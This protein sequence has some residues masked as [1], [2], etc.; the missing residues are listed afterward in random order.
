MRPGVGAAVII[1]PATVAL[2]VGVLSGCGASHS[3][4][5][6]ALARPAAINPAKWEPQ[7]GLDASGRRLISISRT[8][9][10]LHLQ[11]VDQT[12]HPGDPRFADASKRFAGT[13][14][15][16]LRAVVV[17]T[18]HVRSE[19][20]VAEC[21]PAGIGFPITVRLERPLG[22]RALVDGGAPRL[23]GGP[24]VA[25]IRVPAT[26]RTLEREAE[27]HYGRPDVAAVP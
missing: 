7:F 8:A 11:V 20:P 18:V 9:R 6:R 10:E 13:T 15:Q 16:E 23:G 27:S 17:V 4:S 3:S 21:A 25:V 2:M 22:A 12:C 14:V 19:P 1:A 5:S 24:T 26:I